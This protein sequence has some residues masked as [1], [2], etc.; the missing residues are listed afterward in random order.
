MKVNNTLFGPFMREDDIS[1]NAYGNFIAFSTLNTKDTALL[2]L[3]F[4][5]SVYASNLAI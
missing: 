5:N 2:K 1:V 4:N 3:L